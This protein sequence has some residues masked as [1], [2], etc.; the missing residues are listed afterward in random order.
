MALLLVTVT[1][2]VLSGYSF[3]ARSVPGALPFAGLTAGIA[4]WTGAHAYRICATAQDTYFLLANVEW[5]GILVVAP[6]WLLFTL[7]YTGR[8]DDISFRLVTLLS[9]QPAVTL[10]IV[11]SNES[12]GWF[13]QVESFQPAGP[14]LATWTGTNGDVYWL[15]VGYLYLV[16]LVG[17]MVLLGLSRRVPQLYRGRT[18]VLLTGILVPWLGTVPTLLDAR[19]VEGLNLGPL[20][21][22]ASTVAFGVALFGH[23][24]FGVVPVSPSVATDA[25]VEEMSSGV[26]VLDAQGRIAETNP[27]AD[28]I[29]AVSDPV[30]AQLGSVHAELGEAVD[31]GEP[32]NLLLHDLAGRERYVTVETAPVYR[33]GDL[34]VGRIVTLHDVTDRVLREQR[35]DVLN[36]V[37]RHNVRHETNLILGH[38][39][40]LAPGVDT[41]DQVHL[42]AVLDAAEQL[43]DW[44]DRAR[45]V[46]RALDDAEAKRRE[47]PVGS[48]IDRAAER[49]REEYPGAAI[50][51][52][53]SATQSVLAH[54]TLEWALYEL[55]E[56]GVDHADRPDPTVVVGVEADPTQVTVTI[57]D[58]GPGIPEEERRVLES[59]EETPLQ[60]GS[61]LGLW[62][63]NW[64]VRAVGGEIE[65][66]DNEP[67]GTVVRLT[68][69]RAN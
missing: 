40:L 55:I 32:S 26:V 2:I 38:G 15:A 13:R 39:E 33:S 37:L 5:I 56:N 30:G 1:M 27:A 24:L 60:H 19:P 43:V 53:A 47:I 44:S 67:T 68:L 54:T 35:L 69:T 25:V 66:T 14:G 49:V 63:V 8:R 3:R 65:F 57:S 51:T 36:R 16:V 42:D 64:T 50:V 18:A 7:A 10:G 46:E 28:H 22:A 12:H 4:V 11:F 52:P 23:R 41:D 59:G 9:L 20:G 45:Y 6:T 29:L 62:L 61:G 21:F 31:A 58:T 48:A 34:L 17:S